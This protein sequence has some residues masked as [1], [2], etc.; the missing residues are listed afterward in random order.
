MAFVF[1]L[2]Y[3]WNLKGSI[4]YWVFARASTYVCLAYWKYRLLAVFSTLFQR[5]YVCLIRTSSSKQK[6]SNLHCLCFCVLI[7]SGEDAFN[8]NNL[9]VH[10]LNMCL[11]SYFLHWNWELFQETAGQLVTN[12]NIHFPQWVEQYC[13]N[14]WRHI[15]RGFQSWWNCL[16][17]STY[18][19]RSAS[20][21]R[22]S[23][24]L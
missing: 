24:G 10:H 7:A 1:A 21:W 19:W 5:G 20:K 16:Q 18:W 12:T 14:W 15:W 9:I 11:I 23:E 4:N 3:S 6:I 13:Q 22:S 2:L 17:S 8:Y